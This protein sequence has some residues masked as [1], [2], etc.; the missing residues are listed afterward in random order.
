MHVQGRNHLHFLCYFLEGLHTNFIETS[1]LAAVSF[2]S[3]AAL[4]NCVE[5]IGNEVTLA[6]G[7]DFEF[8][9]F[10]SKLRLRRYN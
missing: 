4:R 1:F 8:S 5:G 7:Q 6:A 9:L 3:L 2:R 10:P